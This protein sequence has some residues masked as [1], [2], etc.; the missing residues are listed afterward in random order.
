MK[1]LKDI[2]YKVN[3][4]LIH[5]DRDVIISHLCL[6]SRKVKKG[7]LLVLKTRFLQLQTFT[8]L[9]MSLTL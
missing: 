6:D 8:P 4:N 1:L 5:G 3:L 2:L 7:S 9:L